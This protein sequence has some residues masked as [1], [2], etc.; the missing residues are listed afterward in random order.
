MEPMTSEKP[1][2]SISKP[3][4]PTVATPRWKAWWENTQIL[5]IAII[6]ALLIRSFVAEPRFIPSDSMVPTLQVGDRLVVEKISYRLHPPQFGDIIVFDPPEQ[7][8]RLGYAKDQAFIKRVIGQPGQTVEVRGGKVY[9]NNQPL[10]EPYIAAP[11]SYTL[12]P[13]QVPPDQFF[14]M[15][16]NRN[17]SNDS[18]VWGFLPEQ[19]II[20]R[21][22]LRFFP[23]D[24][25]TFVSPVFDPE[26]LE[27]VS[28]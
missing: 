18:H 1:P 4:A 7:L 28:N 5:V 9:V 24:R 15:G 22:W 16:D 8:Q 11:P 25:V 14:V 10:T 17:N 6:L 20:G 21:A 27:P 3:V 12:K 13:V 26:Q 2:N 19:N 23:F